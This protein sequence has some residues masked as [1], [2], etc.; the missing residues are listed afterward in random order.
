MDKRM[1]ELLSE[2]TPCAINAL[3]LITSQTLS[4]NSDMI[5]RH[6]TLSVNVT[7]HDTSLTVNVTGHDT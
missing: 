5:K 1:N 2:R 3:F 4:K 6:M 7:G